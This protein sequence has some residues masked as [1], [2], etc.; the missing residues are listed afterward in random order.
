M[1]DDSTPIPQTSQ[2]KPIRKLGYLYKGHRGKSAI[3]SR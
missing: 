3:V 1:Y 2:D